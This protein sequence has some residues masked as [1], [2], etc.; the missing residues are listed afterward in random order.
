MGDHAQKLKREEKKRK[1]R[2]MG[3]NSQNITVYQNIINLPLLQKYLGIY[4]FLSTRVPQ[5]RV[6]KKW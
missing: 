2:N 1:E 3:Q 4:Q 6:P 5:T